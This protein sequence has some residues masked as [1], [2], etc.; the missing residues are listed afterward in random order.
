[1]LCYTVRPPPT[2]PLFPYTTLFRSDLHGRVGF[3]NAA[4]A[5]LLG[6]P[7]DRLVGSQL[8]AS[9]PWLNDPV[10][11][12]R[13]RAALLSQHA[14]SFVA[15]RPPHQWLS[16]RLH[17]STT[18][19]SVRISRAGAVRGPNRPAPPPGDAPARLVD[20]SQVL[21]LGG[22]RTEGAGEQD[23]VQLDA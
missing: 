9:V 22:P 8:W 12:D 15:L 23:V 10:H 20:I 19:L 17:P 16:F 3:A 5:D 4:A 7:A 2:P 21:S 1:L 18:G 11:E 14:T 6:V 13:Y